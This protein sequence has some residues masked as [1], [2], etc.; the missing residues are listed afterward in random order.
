VVAALFLV[1]VNHYLR[2][3]VFRGISHSLGRALL[4]GVAAAVAMAISNY[5]LSPWFGTGLVLSVA[6]MMLTLLAGGV[7]LVGL[8][9]RLGVSEAMAFVEVIQAPGNKLRSWFYERS[10]LPSVSGID[11]D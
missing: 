1:A 6:N 7:V 5:C 2:G 9:R 3:E 10:T 8:A 4:S 11:Q